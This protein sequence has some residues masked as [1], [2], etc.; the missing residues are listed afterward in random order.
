MSDDDEQRRLG[1]EI[2]VQPMVGGNIIITFGRVDVELTKEQAEHLKVLLID[3]LE[4]CERDPFL[5]RV[6]ERQ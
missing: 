4:R 3:A 1:M 6:H 2:D 5:R